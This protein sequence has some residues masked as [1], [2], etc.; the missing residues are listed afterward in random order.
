MQ[1]CWQRVCAFF[2]ALSPHTA[3]RRR[4]KRKR[5]RRRRERG[6][7]PC[8][9][10]AC[11]SAMPRPCC[12]RGWAGAFLAPRSS[13]HAGARVSAAAHAQLRPRRVPWTPKRLG[14]GGPWPALFFASGVRGSAA[15]ECLAR[16]LPC[17][18][19]PPGGAVGRIERLAPASAAHPAFEPA[20]ARPAGR[21]ALCPARARAL[22]P[23]W[24]KALTSSLA[25]IRGW[26]AESKQTGQRP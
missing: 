25:C 26:Q 16:L 1:A 21:S 3:T 12:S 19:S 24:E 20:A 17:P 4:H 6:D 13:L 2:T 7:E 18:G 8:L 9:K 5:R 11:R 15:R 22:V 23:A 14:A 10:R